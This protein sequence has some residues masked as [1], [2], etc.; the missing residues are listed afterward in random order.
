MTVHSTHQ[1]SSLIGKNLKSPRVHNGLTLKAPN[2]TAADNIYNIFS[3]FF[4]DSLT[5]T[6]W[7]S[8]FVILSVLGLFCCF[9]LFLVENSVSKQC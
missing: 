5:V 7:M 9:I 1:G 8:P 2:M 6:C 4:R 3:L